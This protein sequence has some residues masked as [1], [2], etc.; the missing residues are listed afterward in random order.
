MSTLWPTVAPSVIQ[1][2]KQKAEKDSTQTSS[3]LWKIRKLVM[4][5]TAETNYYH[6]IIDEFYCAIPSEYD[7]L[8]AKYRP[9]IGPNFFQ[10]LSYVI[11]ATKRN[12]DN[13]KSDNL[14]I[15]YS[16][17]S[18]LIEAYDH[19]IKDKEL[20]Q[21]AINRLQILLNHSSSIHNAE[22]MID[23]I[24]KTNQ[25][26]PALLLILSK[27]YISV[28]NSSF[29][30]TNVADIMTHL[31]FRVQEQL[32]KSK[33]PEVRILKYLLTL[34]DPLKAHTEMIRA[35]HV[36]PNFETKTHEHISTTP[37][38]LIRVIDAVLNAHKKSQRSTTP[39]NKNTEEFP[40]GI[41]RLVT[42]SKILKDKYI[43]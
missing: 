19:V 12:G 30:E 17:I 23:D 11:V 38:K 29:S 27:S 13:I 16:K 25:L 20:I 9:Y 21:D 42:Y 43:D 4:V 2:L 22:I 31:Y 7:A 3:K 33:S 14:Q 5:L 35:L 18:A 36:G 1:H 32:S 24:V 10:H 15:I 6:H 37:D 34:D 28:K 41:K 26:D 39:F 8:H 40:N